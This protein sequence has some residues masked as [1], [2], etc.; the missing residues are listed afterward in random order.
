MKKAF[1]LT[2]LILGCMAPAFAEPYP[3]PMI[4]QPPGPSLPPRSDRAFI[5]LR[6]EMID[7]R[8]L[9]LALQASDGGTL[10]T[11]HRDEIQARIDAAYRRYHNARR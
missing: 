7:L 6:S 8:R 9:G 1:L 10:T 3:A 4:Y 5:L 2:A 11:E